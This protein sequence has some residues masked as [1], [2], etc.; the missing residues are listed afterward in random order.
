[1]QQKIIGRVLV[2]KRFEKAKRIVRGD[3]CTRDGLIGYPRFGV[4][5][6]LVCL[7]CRLACKGNKRKTMMKANDPKIQGI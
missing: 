4:D 6:N 5:L 1:L 2:R 3:P 7:R